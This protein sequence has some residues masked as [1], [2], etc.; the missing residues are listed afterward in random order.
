MR[1]LSI[2]GQVSAAGFL[3][4]TEWVGILKEFPLKRQF[5]K[6]I[7]QSIDKDSGRSLTESV[8]A[9]VTYTSEKLKGR[10]YLTSLGLVITLD[11]DGI[12][13]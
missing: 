6:G 11:R 7:P 9:Q 1:L 12:A 8:C 10:H 3:I 2:E 13:A 4:E 5:N